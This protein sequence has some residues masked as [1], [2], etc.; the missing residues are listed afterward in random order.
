MEYC[1]DEQFNDINALL[2]EIRD[3]IRFLA[4][5]FKSRKEEIE[6]IERSREEITNIHLRGKPFDTERYGD[7]LPRC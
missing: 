4:Q 3:D 5:F 6:R 1:Y 2:S 7:R